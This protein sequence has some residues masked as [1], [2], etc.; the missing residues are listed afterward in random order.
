MESQLIDRPVARLETGSPARAARVEH[1]TVVSTYGGVL[2]CVNIQ[3]VGGC[4]PVEKLTRLPGSHERVAGVLLFKGRPV[5]LVSVRHN[6]AGGPR[7]R[8]RHEEHAL[9]VSVRGREF[10]LKVDGAPSVVD[11]PLPY[12]SSADAPCVMRARH[13]ERFL[14]LCVSGG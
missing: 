9:V 8:Q 2:V 4:V 10:A 6:R 13:L 5:P 7:H 11:G 12:A 14:A 3:Q 1:K